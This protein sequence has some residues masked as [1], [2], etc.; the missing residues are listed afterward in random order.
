MMKKADE[1]DCVPDE[2]LAAVCGLFCPACTIFIGTR[3]HPARLQVLAE[4]LQKP[5]EELHCDGC[6]SGRRCFYCRDKCQMAKCASGRGVTFCGACEDYPCEELKIF[7]AE[8]PHRIELWE[9]QKRIK[10]A[11]FE[12]WFAEMVRHYSCPECGALNSAYDIACRKCGTD[13]SCAYLQLHKDEIM[14]GLS[15]MK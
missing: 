11:G 12:K 3:E 1:A 10:E 7:Q 14:K 13:P 15:R 4:R 2:R 5:V 8:M 9:S 6:R